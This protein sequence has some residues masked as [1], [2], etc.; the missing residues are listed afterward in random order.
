MRQTSASRFPAQSDERGPSLTDGQSAQV[1]IVGIGTS[2]GGLPALE[3]FFLNIPGNSGLAYVV[4]QHLDPTQK[5]L[6]VELLQRMTTMPVRQAEPMLAVVANCVYVIAP[7]TEIS[8]N[9][10]ILLVT[11]PSEPRGLRLPINVLFSS[12]ARDQR[13]LAIAVVLS[14]MGSDGTLGLQAIKALG[15]LSAVQQP[16]SA[17]FDSMPKSAIAAG[18]GDIVALP[19]DLPGRIL[20][21]IHRTSEREALA[22]AGAE[23]AAVSTVEPMQRIFTLVHQ[24]TKHDFSLYKSNTIQRRVE[25]R[26]AIHSLATRSTYADYLEANPQEVALLF[27]ELLIG[28]TSFFRDPPVWQQL[29]EIMVPQLLERQHDNSVLRAWVVGCST[30]E[31][32]YS[33]AMVFAETVQKFPEHRERTLQIFATDINPDAIATAR[34]GEYPASSAA[35][36]GEPRLSQYFSQ[37]GGVLR[38]VKPIRD[39]VLFAQQ[40]VILEPP[41]TRLISF[42]VEI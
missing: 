38:I 10:G 35:D 33:L 20:S 29:A 11:A 22:T 25:R 42:A 7:N 6:L 41:F 26:M 2:A 1:R 28:V 18:C 32:A 31:E 30:G 17:Q 39:M 34:K 12:L 13:E 14:G 21:T 16:E 24:Q 27:K 15:G 23:S 8:V 3:Q 5:A 9:N 37:S 19:A 4:V 40:D 36:I